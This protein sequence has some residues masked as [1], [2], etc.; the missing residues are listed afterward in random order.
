MVKVICSGGTSVS[1]SNDD[2]VTLWWQIF[3]T[4]IVVQLME[5]GSPEWKC[6]VGVWIVGFVFQVHDSYNKMGRQ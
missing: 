2:Q 4:A 1:C 3:A 5:L 6:R